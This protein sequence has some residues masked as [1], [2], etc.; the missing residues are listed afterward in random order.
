MKVCSIF[1][2]DVTVNVFE[3]KYQNPLKVLL[4]K[5]GTKRQVQLSQPDTAGFPEHVLSLAP[6]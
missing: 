4:R 6:G 2:S 5:C 1:F 3:Y